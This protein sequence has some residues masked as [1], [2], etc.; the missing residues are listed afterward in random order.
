M[1]K[2]IIFD[3]DGTLTKRLENVYLLYNDFFKKYFFDLDEI[4]YEAVIQ[5]LMYYEC[6]GTIVLRDRMI[7]FRK[8]YSKY[9]NDEVVETFVDYYRNNMYKYC[10]LKPETLDVLNKLKGKYK[11]GIL[12]NGDSKTQHD[13]VDKFGL[14]KYFDKV[15]ISGDVDIEK[16]DT[17]IYRI[18]VDAL[19]V[20]ANECLFIGDTYSTDILGAIKSNMIPIWMKMDREK[21]TSYKGYMINNLEEVFEILKKENN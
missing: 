17:R 14:E 19:G 13:K 8:K 21:P 3:F 6:N 10:N 9:I 7:Q 2:A 1:I 11:L 12:S 20:Q 15:L 16:P 18:M 5:D 4:E